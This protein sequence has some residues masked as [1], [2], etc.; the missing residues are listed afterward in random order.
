MAA[1]RDDSTSSDA[2]GA[3]VASV[4]ASSYGTILMRIDS[5]RQ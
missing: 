2:A 1:S 5:F 4:A 3:D